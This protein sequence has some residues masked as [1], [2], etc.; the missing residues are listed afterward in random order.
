M[1]ND[2]AA[3]WDRG[4][5][6]TIIDCLKDGI[7]PPPEA[8]EAL[9]VGYESHLEQAKIGLDKA[10]AGGYDVMLLEGRYG[11]GKS[12]LLSIIE[13]VAK[14]QGFVVKRV[15]VGKGR[16]YLNSPRPFFKQILCGESE[17]WKSEYREYGP[18]YADQIREFVAGLKILTRRHLR[19]GT[20]GMVILLDELEGTFNLSQ[21]LSRRKA[22]RVL[23]ALFK[24]WVSHPEYLNHWTKNRSRLELDHLYLVMA[25][26]PGTLD[27]AGMDGPWTSPINYTNPAE[28]WTN[29]PKREIRPLEYPNAL[30]LAQRVRVVHNKAFDWQASDFVSDAQLEQ[31]CQTWCSHGEMRDD[32]ELVKRVIELLEIAE[33]NR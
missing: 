18:Y 23:D 30:D 27:R 10:R 4:R 5:C 24:G 3:T 22:Y 8:I 17:P 6:R 25:V 11:I 12:H 21:F 13:V 14:Q 15:E 26:T 16:V 28:N 32:R 20:P 1:D 2:L 31:L 9:S 7:P 29:L 33:Q 19:N